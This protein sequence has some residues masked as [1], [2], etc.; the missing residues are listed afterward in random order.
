MPQSAG[1]LPLPDDLDPLDQAR[2]LVVRGSAAMDRILALIESKIAAGDRYDDKL[3]SHYAWMMQ[4]QVQAMEGLRKVDAHYHRWAKAAS[5]EERDALVL[6][7][8]RAMPPA[9]RA[10]MRAALDELEED[11]ALLS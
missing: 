9:R 1:S 2:Q 4:K 10:E 5:A 6:A 11:R 8:L 3:G 7:Y